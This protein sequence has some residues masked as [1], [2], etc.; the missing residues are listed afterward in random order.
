MNTKATSA[1]LTLFITIAIVVM[2]NYLVSG[3]NIMNLRVDL[4][5]KKIFT[6]SE[7]TKKII[8]SISKDE[9]VT[10]RFYATQDSRI[11]PQ[12][13][14]NY[15]KSVRDLLLEM[16]KEGGGR[17]KLETV[18]PRPNTEEEEKAMTDQILGMPGARGGEKAYLGLAVE[19]VGSKQIVPVLHPR[20]EISL[21]YYV[22]RALY[23]TIHPESDR[24]VVGLMSGMP[25]GGPPLNFPGMPQRQ[26]PAW[27]SI[28]FMKEDHDVREVSTNAETIDESVKVLVVI[29]PADITPQAE[30]AIDQFLLRGGR[31]VVFLDPA[32]RS[33]RMYNSQG[34]LGMMAPTFVSPTSNLPSLLKAWGVSYNAGEMLADMKHTTQTSNNYKSPTVL[35]LGG[36]AINADEPVTSNLEGMLMVGAGGFAVAEKPGIKV[37]RLINSSA[38][39]QFVD[40]ATGEQAFTDPLKGFKSDGTVKSMGL[41]LTG[42][43][44]TAF[45]EGRP[46]EPAP[47]GGPQ[48]PKETGGE[49]KKDAGAPAAAAAGLKESK[50][51]QGMIFLFSDVDML[52]DIFALYRDPQGGGLQ[53]IPGNANIP[54]LLNA[55][56]M[57]T[58]GIDLIAVRS[59]ARAQ[60][61]FTKMNEL[62]A[63]V[64]KKYVPILDGLEKEKAAVAKQ[65]AD[66][67]GAKRIGNVTVI[68]GSEEQLKPLYAK[69]LEI[70]KKEREAA[71]ELNR[72]RDRVNLWITVL[73]M[74]AVPLLVIIFGV[75]V[76]L[77]RRS[78][79]AAH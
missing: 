63:D 43:F 33:S 6:L 26:P 35:T 32:C 28:R 1:L 5:E 7:G 38:E 25:I 21:E 27:M 56:E 34:Q 68:E 64:E 44:T 70:R 79:Q 37:V 15:A 14:L 76:A 3:L 59:R 66:I 4:T 20:E 42:R 48:A 54:L 75:V 50:D 55:V 9:P 13:M 30:Y 41:R 46:K 45:P 31:L 29:H 19:A 73:N 24:P 10:L 74:A 12:A 51:D 40:T 17:I 16:E 77:R 18:D 8:G 69:E 2:V 36:D 71:K 58:G 53:P 65:I 57:A 67:N 60:R 47:E 72:D 52:A 61:E 11:M 78:L 49:E 22:A 23:K 62:L 39:S